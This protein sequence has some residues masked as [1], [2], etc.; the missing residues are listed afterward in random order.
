MSPSVIRSSVSGAEF[1]AAVRHRPPDGEEDAELFGAA[2]LPPDEAG[3]AAASSNLANAALFH[4]PS[5]RIVRVLTDASGGVRPMR[6]N[7]LDGS[8]LKCQDA[9]HAALMHRFAEIP[10]CPSFPPIS[11]CR[12]LSAR[13]WTGRRRPPAGFEAIEIQ[14]L[15]DRPAEDW[16][17]A[18]E[19]AGLVV[20]VINVPVGDMH[21]RG[22]RRRPFSTAMSAP[23]PSSSGFPDRSS[24]TPRPWRWRGS[25]ATAPAGAPGRSR[26]CS[27][28]ICSAT[29][30]V[31]PARATTRGRSKPW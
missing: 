30:S 28:T 13:G 14:F 9:V 15:Y 4:V 5:S 11:R 2:V 19:A 1:Y 29:G 12:S 23:S 25:W 27:R 26:I 7:S 6:S 31:G 22:R 3:A 10:T 16:Q 20:S 17:R 24:M 21:I 18:I 8:A